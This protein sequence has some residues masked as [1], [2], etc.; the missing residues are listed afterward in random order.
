MLIVI[1]SVHGAQLTGR[2]IVD[3]SQNRAEQIALP[4][5]NAASR[6][7]ERKMRRLR[8]THAVREA[9]VV[10]LHGAAT[11]A[12]VTPRDQEE[13]FP[14]FGT[15]VF[16]VTSVPD[17][18]RMT[19]PT[20]WNRRF[21][22]MPESVF[23]PLPPYDL[24]VLSRPLQT[25]LR[26]RWANVDL[27]T[28]KL[29]YSTRF[30]GAYDLDAGEFTGNHPGIDIKL[31]AGTPLGSVAGGRVDSVRE[32]PG[33]GLTVI[34]EH[35]HPTDGTFYSVYGHLEISTV[36]EGQALSAGDMLGT[37]GMT[38]T[39]TAPHVHWQIDRGR[40]GGGH[41]PYVPFLL[42]SAQEADRFTVH[43]IEF[44]QRYGVAMPERNVV[45]R[46]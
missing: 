40:A 44:V 31:A 43:P 39:T 2:L 17:W 10:L 14:P 26:D 41:V 20:E 30:F 27:L 21:E 38:G 19:T 4:V 36:R 1:A 33:L 24:H 23:V 34:V 45:I 46:Q 9:T 3:E 8:T 29:T 32:R 22:E 37:V 7:L 25:L 35:R 12:T 16:P 6:R 5:S 13:P 18:G 28:A 11:P 15:A 42:P